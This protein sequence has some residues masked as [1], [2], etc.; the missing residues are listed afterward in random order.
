M[1]DPAVSAP[2][3]TGA[4]APAGAPAGADPAAGGVA[5]AQAGQAG[6]PGAPAG[7]PNGGQPGAAPSME[8]F[9]DRERAFLTTAHDERGK[10]QALEAEV[11]ELRAQLQ[12]RPA[13]PAQPAQSAA[14]PADPF[15]QIDDDDLLTGGQVKNLIQTGIMPMFQQLAATLTMIQRGQQHPDMNEAISTYLPQVLQADPAV[16][17][18]LNAV[19]GPAKMILAH[20]LGSLAKRAAGGQPPTPPAGG[21]GGAPDINELA[22]QILANAGK[23]GPA[24]AGGGSAIDPLVA[25]ISSMTPQQFAAYKADLQRKWAAQGY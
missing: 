21:G 22:R 8:D 12:S 25:Q 19:Q 11:A 3:A 13:G 23:P 15:S 24:G 5:G 17:Q 9:T 1:G 16:A 18:A 2:A 14:A 6:T 10:R 4:A 7:E 20:A